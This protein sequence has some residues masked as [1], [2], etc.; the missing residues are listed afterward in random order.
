LC[1][2]VVGGIVEKSGE[3]ED[4]DIGRWWRC[5]SVIV[6]GKGCSASSTV[7]PACLRWRNDTSETTGEQQQQQY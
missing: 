3:N 7:D 6:V 5:D 1:E 2:H 4:L